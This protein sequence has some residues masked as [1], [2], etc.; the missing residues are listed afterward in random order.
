M[1]VSAADRASALDRRQTPDAGAPPHGA[2][3]TAAAARPPRNDV[4]LSQ[5][6]SSAQPQIQGLGEPPPYTGDLP[7]PLQVM[8]HVPSGVGDAFY[9]S[10]QNIRGWVDDA[11]RYHGV[12]TELLAAVLQNENNPNASTLNQVLQFGE[13]SLTTFS[14]I[15]D[16]AAFGLAP[17]FA[18]GGSSGIANMS[19][20]A[21]HSGAAYVENTLGRAVIPDDVASRVLGWRQDS[22]ISG[23]D[24]RS[25][26]YYAAAHL[27]ELTDR[28]TGVKNYDG[29][30][31]RQ[32]VHDIAAAY[33]GSGP[34]ASR[35]GDVAVQHIERAVA[36]ERP[37]YFYQPR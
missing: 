12:P 8:W 10:D 21:V 30:L 29:P 14:D 11:A 37:L 36:G 18:S 28:V 22:R 9:V 26:L 25:D 35:Y 16:R 3:Q 20:N 5:Q 6:P 34:A 32:L 15:L 17:D 2:T 33:N 1:E 31:S 27:R 19:R 13:R 7:S 23:D 4:A 24:L